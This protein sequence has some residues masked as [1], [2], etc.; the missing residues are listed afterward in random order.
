MNTE[1]ARLFSTMDSSIRR[2]P[3]IFAASSRYSLIW[4]TSTCEMKLISDGYATVEF[5][6]PINDDVQ[7][8]RRSLCRWFLDHEK[9]L[10]IQSDV[11]TCSINSIE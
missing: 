6:E 3:V 1:A 2:S 8:V 10:A 7:L 9:S 4:V 11:I 5:F